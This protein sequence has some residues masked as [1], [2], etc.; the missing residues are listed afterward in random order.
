MHALVDGNINFGGGSP[1]YHQSVAVVLLLETADVVAQHL[2]HLPARRHDDSTVSSHNRLHIVTIKAAGVGAV[3]SGRH[4]LYLLQLVAHA[5]NVVLAEHLGVERTLIGIQ[6]IDIPAAEDKVVKTRQGHYIAVFQVLLVSTTTHAYLV[7][8]GHGTYRFAQAAAGHK[9]TR[10][11]GSGYG[12]V[13]Y[14]Q[15]SQSAV[16]R[17]YIC[18]FH[19]NYFLK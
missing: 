15:D 4:G 16:G 18:C 8:L 11:E 6:G 7:V 5:V 12:A 19:F 14:H 13:A 1:Q 9:D 10:H 2:Y 17:L 3:E